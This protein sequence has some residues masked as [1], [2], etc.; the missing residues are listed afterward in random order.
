MQRKNASKNAFTLIELL[1]VIAIIAILA[2]ILFPV[3][4]QARSKARQTT[5]L[6]NEK[7]L[8]IALMAYTQDYDEQFP[9]A[10]YDI[11]TTDRVHWYNLIEPY[12]KANYTRAN[13]NLGKGMSIYVCPDFAKTQNTDFG[14]QQSWSYVCN[15]NLMPPPAASGSQ[16][17]PPTWAAITPKSLAYL[18][19]PA[20]VVLA[21]EGDGRRVYTQGN[22]TGVYETS[23]PT[24]IDNNLTYIFA[25]TR[26]NGGANYLLGDGHAKWYKAPDPSYTGGAGADFM[27]AVPRTSTAGVVYR[28]SQYPNAGAWFRED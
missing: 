11:S 22:D 5:C 12:V 20:Q 15:F 23:N 18:Q 6:S 9:L 10:N 1:V 19:A 21:A 14:I 13:A 2:A 8:G 4:A 17:L 24:E 28:Q 7:Q 3:F 27:N 25:R 26:H 16:S